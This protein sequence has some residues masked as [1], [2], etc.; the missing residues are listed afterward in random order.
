[1]TLIRLFVGRLLTGGQDL[2]RRYAHLNWALLDQIIVSGSNFALGVIIARCLGIEAF[3]VFSLAW[4][5]VLF[6]QSLQTALVLAPMM[7]IGPKQTAGD[8]SAYY[9]VV[10]VHQCILAAAASGLVL[11][12]VGNGGLFGLPE[13]ATQLA[14][15][16]ALATLLVQ[17]QE[18][19]RRY[20]FTLGASE[21]V[22]IAD[23]VRYG[24]LIGTMLIAVTTSPK[25]P[26][27]DLVLYLVAAS[28]GVSALTM[29][30][31]RPELQGWSQQFAAVTRRHARFSRW[32]V[33]SALLFWTTGNIVVVAA[34]ALLG[35]H[36]A[37]A[38]KAGQALMAVTHVFFQTAESVIPPRA[39]RI[40]HQGGKSAL[41]DFT[42]RVMI[43]GAVVTGIACV[44]LALPGEFWLAAL[45]GADYAGYGFLVAG[46][47]LYYF[48]S[49]CVQPLRWALQAAE[50]T[51]AD[52]I[53]YAAGA[54]FTLITCY[55]LVNAFGLAGAIICIIGSQAL[56]LVWLFFQYRSFMRSPG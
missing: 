43:V 16:I 52:F 49:A 8:A 37:G 18:F 33:G 38:L 45:F 11:L 31:G 54:A 23:M 27:V 21:R 17:L 19:L 41:R 46:F 2:G 7:T 35:A 25:M 9:A 6:T 3:G 22:A 5:V 14:L 53:A 29:L 32:A 36:A 10:L 44:L 26:G 13:A 15:P 12:L 51:R 50:A 34:G 42:R 39:A 47:G 28:A 55:P 30:A 56:M 24:G 48:L 1:M 40:F 4:L 20:N